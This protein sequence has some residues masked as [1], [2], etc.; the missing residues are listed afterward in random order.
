MTGAGGR[1]A[2]SPLSVERNDQGIALEAGAGD[3]LLREDVGQDDVAADAADPHDQL[4]A[5][6]QQADFLSW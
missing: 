4:L 2:G 3:V 1:C 6:T 5:G